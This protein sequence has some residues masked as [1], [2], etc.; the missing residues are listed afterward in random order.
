V[1]K[2][3]SSTPAE[4][5]AMQYAIF[6]AMPANY[7]VNEGRI[8]NIDKPGGRKNIWGNHRIPEIIF[9]LMK[10]VKMKFITANPNEYLVIGYGGKVKNYGSGIRVFLWPG[11]TYVLIPSTK[12]E[13]RFEMTQETKDGIP[14]HFKGI[15]VYRITRPELAAINF[16]FHK[17]GGLGEINALICDFCLGELRAVVSGMIMN[18]CIEQRKTILTGTVETA[19]K[20]IIHG[21]NDSET[22]D[23]G[24]ELEMIQVAQVYIID[25]DLR[26]HLEAEV[27]NQIRAKSDQS[28]IRTLEENQLTQ[29]A[30]NRR[31]EEQKLISEKAAI[32]QKEE[33]D[34]ANL[35]YRNRIQKENQKIINETI[36]LATEKFKHEQEAE[37]E[38]SAVETPVKLYQIEQ[39]R[40][41]QAQKLELMQIENQVR[42]LEV[43]RDLI[44][45][46]AR[47]DLK[48]EIMPVEQLP[49]IADSLSK[50]FQ[51]ANLSYFGS[52]NQ[53][54]GSIL[55]LFDIF[56][57]MISQKIEDDGHV[58]E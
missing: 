55:P 34:L 47:Q 31:I 56:S 39:Q 40:S 48:K 25:N 20:N 28:D 51:G 7:S 32:Q 18:E 13:T 4:I 58:K 19:L 37:R 57:K 24:I 38:K 52:E 30:S 35:Q 10:G 29:L 12:Q 44:L 9:K 22:P 46:R 21:E 17:G 1:S 36:L 5:S 16:N 14:L 23:W 8:I 43:A 11:S 2:Y 33:V 53:I 6:S 3:P 45:E 49:E 50:I 41:I 42:G 26:K 54:L 15:V 27:R